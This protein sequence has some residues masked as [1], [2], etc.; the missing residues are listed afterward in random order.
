M[1]SVL[2]LSPPREHAAKLMEDNAFY[3]SLLAEHR[4]RS[5]QEGAQLLWRGRGD[6]SAAVVVEAENGFDQELAPRIPQK[7]AG[8]E[9]GGVLLHVD[10]EE[11]IDQHL[12]AVSVISH[13]RTA[14]PAPG[15]G[16][17]TAAKQPQFHLLHVL[18][19]SK[20]F[21]AELFQSVRQFPGRKQTLSITCLQLPGLGQFFSGRSFVEG[22]YQIGA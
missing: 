5:P 1:W 10:P 15:P 2:P 4:G 3:C 11:D 7:T 8:V 18:P 13:V 14:T 17:A 9:V 20:G 21:L 22:C 19:Q 16:C 12:D 6:D